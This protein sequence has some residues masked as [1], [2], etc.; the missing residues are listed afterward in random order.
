MDSIAL[1]ELARVIINTEAT[2]AASLVSLIDGAIVAA[3]RSN[4]DG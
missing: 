4:L 2:A 3:C 1:K